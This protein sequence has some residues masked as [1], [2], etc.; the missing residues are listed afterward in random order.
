[1]ST[2]YRA[3]SGLQ[4]ALLN[5]AREASIRSSTHTDIEAEIR[6][7]L[8]LVSVVSPEIQLTPEIITPETSNIEISITIDATL[9]N[10]FFLNRY[11]MGSMVRTL[12]YKGI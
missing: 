8:L 3:N 5:G 6:E 9:E 2:V 11:F 1:M 10:G 4:T 7:S 12:S